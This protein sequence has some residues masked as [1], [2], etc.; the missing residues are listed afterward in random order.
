M[1]DRLHTRRETVERS[2]AQRERTL[3]NLSDSILLYD[4]TSTYFEGL[5]EAN[6]KA[7][8]GYSRDGR[9]DCKQVVIGLVLDGEGFPRA[10]EVFAGNTADSSSVEAMLDALEKR[11]GRRAGATVVVDRGMSGAA[12]LALIRARGY[13]YIVACRQG[14]RDGVYDD[15]TS[16]P[17][18]TKVLREPSPTNP[19]QRKTA[20]RVKRI[21]GDGCTYLGVHSAERVDKDRAIREKHEARLLADLERLRL[22][23]AAGKLVDPDAI[24]E[25]IGSIRQ[26]HTRVARY[27]D[28]DLD[29]QGQLRIVLDQ[30]RRNVS[31]LAR[32]FDPSITVLHDRCPEVSWPGLG[33][34]RWRYRGDNAGVLTAGVGWS[35]TCAMARG[36]LSPRAVH[37]PWCGR[38][39]S[40]SCGLGVGG[41][42]LLVIPADFPGPLGHRHAPGHRHAGVDGAGRVGE[43][44]AQRRLLRVRRPGP[45]AAQGAG[46]GSG[47]LL[48]VHPSA[49]RRDLCRPP[50]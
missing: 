20:V 47:R 39:S 36:W 48:A 32:R 9:P 27:Y 11:I 15:L 25:R 29:P 31:A 16:E 22:R 42:E 30:Q 2:L 10:H 24:H 23:I 8:R 4:L 45:P 37:R 28:V 7:Q 33:S 35:S 43:R 1:L 41:A 6:P 17:G 40:R 21:A 34:C 50:L 14:E 18:W 46:L 5:A 38:S 12:N 3:F 19:C 13:R 26:R 44:S 49:R